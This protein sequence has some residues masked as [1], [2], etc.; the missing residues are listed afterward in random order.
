MIMGEQLSDQ[1][2]RIVEFS[3]DATSGTRANFVRDAEQHDRV[4]KEFF[5]RTGEDYYRFNYLGEWHTHPSFSVNPSL[6]DVNAM[7]D[8]VD[9]TG[10]V[11]FAVLL[12]SRLKW[13]W[14]YECSANL[15]LRDHQPVGVEIKRD[16]AKT[17]GSL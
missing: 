11:D 14:Q 12:I 17:E 16:D 9:G 7:Q 5:E 10:G 2:F 15:F 8:L 6:Q 13:F 1:Q 3:V 4:L